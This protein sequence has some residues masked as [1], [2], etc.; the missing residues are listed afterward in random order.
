[1]W[2]AEQ[3]S[4]LLTA[5]ECERLQPPWMLIASTGM[6]R[7]EGL[8][9]RWSDVDLVE[10]SLIV[11]QGDRC[12]RQAPR[13]EGTEDHHE[14]A[15]PP[16]IRANP[17]GTPDPPEASPRGEVRGRTRVVTDTARLTDE[18]GRTLDPASVSDAFKRAVKMSGLP[19]LDPG[20]DS[21][22]RSLQSASRLGWTCCTRRRCSV[23]ALRR[24]HNPSISTPGGTA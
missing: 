17:R 6:R 24:L 23:T 22:T 3:V 1:V 18:F 16:A 19:P 21:G 7:S 14:A 8:G 15:N 13:D 10:G 9:L 4:V 2:T 12:L 11:R 5:S 20:R